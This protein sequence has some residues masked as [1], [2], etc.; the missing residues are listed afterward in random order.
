MDDNVDDNNDIVVVVEEI[1]KK[2]PEAAYKYMSERK[3]LFIMPGQN[4]ARTQR[5]QNDISF[6]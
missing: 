4:C 5:Q 1:I 2:I 6:G 3:T